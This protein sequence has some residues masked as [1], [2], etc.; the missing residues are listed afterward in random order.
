MYVYVKENKNSRFQIYGINFGSVR[1]FSWVL[2]I[3]FQFLGYKHFACFPYFVQFFNIYF[4]FVFWMQYFYI[5]IQV[6]A[7]VLKSIEVLKSYCNCIWKK[8]P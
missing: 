4:F 6:Y 8:L 7:F 1:R 2:R 3:S 5:L